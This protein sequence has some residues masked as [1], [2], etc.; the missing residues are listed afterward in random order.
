MV[1][2][3]GTLMPLAREAPPS[4]LP[5]STAHGWEAFISFSSN[6]NINKNAAACVGKAAVCMLHPGAQALCKSS[7][8]VFIN[9]AAAVFVTGLTSCGA[10]VV[11]G[12]SDVRI[13]S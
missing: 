12:S 1:F 2:D 5:A 9:N 6:V 3:L 10:P 4:L 8:T 7:E 11:T 13:G